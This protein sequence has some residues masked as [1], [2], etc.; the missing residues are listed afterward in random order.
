MNMYEERNSIPNNVEEKTILIYEG[1]KRHQISKGD[2][3]V[4]KRQ[5]NSWVPLSKCVF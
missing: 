1:I 4:L 2:F 5:N 3:R